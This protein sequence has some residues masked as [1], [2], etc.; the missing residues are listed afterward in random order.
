MS[1][2]NKAL[3]DLRSQLW[4][5]NVKSEIDKNSI[6]YVAALLAIRH[7]LGV[8]HPGEISGRIYEEGV[9]TY[10]DGYLWDVEGDSEAIKHRIN[11]KYYQIVR[12]AICWAF[13]HFESQGGDELVTLPVPDTDQFKAVGNTRV[14]YSVI[15]KPHQIE[16]ISNIRGDKYYK[17]YID[18]FYKEGDE[19]TSEWAEYFPTP[20][21][22]TPYNSYSSLTFLMV[23]NEQ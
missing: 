11:P 10:F 9:F 20:G 23:R 2:E 21:A 7:D 14:G 8:T 3:N 13:E 17:R 18:Q 19:I 12:D 4:Q 5:Q 6:S 22:E 15:V 16:F 1:K